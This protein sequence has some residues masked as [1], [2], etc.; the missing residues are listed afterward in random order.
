VLPKDTAIRHPLQYLRYRPR[1]AATRR[2]SRQSLAALRAAG[3]A[4]A[5]PL[6]VLRD[7]STM[8]APLA[9]AGVA[10]ALALALAL[11]GLALAGKSAAQD[12]VRLGQL[13]TEGHGVAGTVYALSDRLVEVRGFRYDGRGP[14][15]FFWVDKGA[16]ATAKGALVPARPSCGGGKLG[17]G[18]GEDLVLELP[19]GLNE[20]GYLSVWCRAV[21]AS[22]G[23]L[24][25]VQRLVAG[26]KITAAAE[27]EC[28]GVSSGGGNGGGAT[29]EEP[30][31]VADGWNC[32]VLL[33]DEMQVRWKVSGGDISVEMVG[34]ITD[35]QYMAFGPSGSDT[36]TAMVGGD[37]A[38][39]LRGV[40]GEYV[41]LD[42]FMTSQ[43][44]CNGDGNGV[45]PDTAASAADD[46]LSAVEGE[47]HGDLVRVQYT[48]PM[49]AVDEDHDRA[50]KE[51]GDTYVTWAIGPVSVLGSGDQLPAYHAGKTIPA[52]KNVAFDFGRSTE[53][54]SCSPLLT[55]ATAAEMDVPP[56]DRPVLPLEEGHEVFARIGP[57]GGNRGLS[58]I[59]GRVGWGIAW[60]MQQGRE[61]VPVL[62]ATL[63][64]ERGKTYT[65]R[66]QGGD[67][68]EARPAYH[69][70]YITS[71]KDGGGQDGAKETIF[72]E[73]VSGKLCEFSEG[74]DSGAAV[75]YG[76][77]VGSLD[78][79]CVDD[80]EVSRGAGTLKWTVAADTPDI[81]YYQCRAHAFLGWKIRVFDKGTMTAAALEEIN[82][83]QS[84]RAG[85]EPCKVTFKGVERS[86]HACRK[87]LSGAVDVYWTIEG[88]RITTLFSAEAE[89]GGYVSWGWGQKMM[90]VGDGSGAAV[91]AYADPNSGEAIIKDY[92][93]TAKTSEGVQ[94]KTPT[95]ISGEE[96]EV[97]SGRVKGLYT[98]PL[99]EKVVNG[100]SDA[101]CSAGLY[102][103]D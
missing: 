70:L 83:E 89:D 66:V 82:V 25:I 46:H 76:D 88:D 18:D 26:L 38:V 48:R 12:A 7:P 51:K 65:F 68:P 2:A 44:A 75:S 85:E 6:H 33:G 98:R 13:S 5:P 31:V 93:M 45:C 87:G 55:K 40:G 78:T 72:A 96:A 97:A 62:A 95:V 84:A 54:K 14:D 67:N 64:V 100:P 37:P 1:L 34:R 23:G 56:I 41:A 30:F 24:A 63:G 9:P 36:K 91:V 99:S 39:A 58:A 74:K 11:A 27:F 61:G 17:K 32:E 22:F 15:A 102:S 59:S 69:P 16:R 28:D 81:V 10:L 52:G 94:P 21:G 86:F 29:G 53:A 8:R 80:A 19:V 60:Y 71:S 35:E 77:Y 43:G 3:H 42:Y 90:T 47:R 92:S 49:A 50:F 79:S 101:V 20:V 57:S 73:A 4:P 103:C